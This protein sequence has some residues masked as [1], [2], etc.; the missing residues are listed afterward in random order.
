M[1]IVVDTSLLVML[2]H[3]HPNAVFMNTHQMVSELGGRMRLC[4]LYIFIEK[5]SFQDNF[6]KTIVYLKVY[7]FLNLTTW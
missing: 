6:I 3:W 1:I 2:S 4:E 5:S 7:V